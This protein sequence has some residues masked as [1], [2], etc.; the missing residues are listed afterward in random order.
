MTF[1]P[2]HKSAGTPDGG[3]FAKRIAL[4]H[5]GDEEDRH[6]IQDKAV[7]ALKAR[8]IIDEEAWVS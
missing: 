8:G 5:H 3:Q 2:V 4:E 7:A 6:N 1:T